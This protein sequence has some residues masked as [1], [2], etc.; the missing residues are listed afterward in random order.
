MPPHCVPRRGADLMRWA[1]STGTVGLGLLLSAA[2]AL[3]LEAPA[4]AEVVAKSSTDLARLGGESP[5]IGVCRPHPVAD[6]DPYYRIEMV[7]TRNVTGTAFVRGHADVTFLRS[8]Y[9][10]SLAADGSYRQNVHLQ[11]EGLRPAPHGSE[12]VAWV[13]TTQIDHVE[14]IGTLDEAGRVMGPVSW[15]KFLVVV[16]LEAQGLEGASAASGSASRSDSQTDLAAGAGAGLSSGLSWSG[17]VAFRGMSRS[18][19]MHTMVGHGPLQ[20]ENCAA[21]G[22]SR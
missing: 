5:G 9:G 10:I 2:A 21:Y 14:R 20:D 12:W 3:G 16:T 15:N 22:F 17:P 1:R 8:P 7:P 13:T 19:M 4:A 11:F 18:G 6:P